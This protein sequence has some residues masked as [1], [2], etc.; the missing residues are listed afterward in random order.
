MVST[1]LSFLCSCRSVRLVI[2]LVEGG[3]GFTFLRL[4]RVTRVVS[5]AAHLNVNLSTRRRLSLQSAFGFSCRVHIVQT[6][7]MGSNLSSHKHEIAL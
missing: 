6:V 2:R 4:V 7:P 3:H 1:E 5:Y